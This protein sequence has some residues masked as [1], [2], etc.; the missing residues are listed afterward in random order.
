MDEAFS[1]SS[2]AVAGRIIAALR[3]FGLHPLFIT[4][5]KEITLLRKHTRSAV[6][7]HNKNTRS[8]MTSLSWEVIEQQAQQRKGQKREIAD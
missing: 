4:P 3:E 8:S 6:L 5:N 7:V 2:Q 1:R